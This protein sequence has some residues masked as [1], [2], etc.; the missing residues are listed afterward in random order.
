MQHQMALSLGGEIN[1]INSYM[2]Y[3]KSL[4]NSL[5]EMQS[6]RIGMKLDVFQ[7]KVKD[8]WWIYGNENVKNNVLDEI[9]ILKCSNTLNNFK[10]SV[11]ITTFLVK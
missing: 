1:R 7:E 3:I 5:D 6:K 10:D 9:V 8:E 4:K 2:T 11:K